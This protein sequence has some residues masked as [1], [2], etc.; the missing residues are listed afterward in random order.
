VAA[1]VLWSFSFQINDKMMSKMKQV[2][3][4]LTC[5]RRKHGESKSVISQHQT[6]LM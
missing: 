3:R 5:K 1:R 6:N 4:D 2:W